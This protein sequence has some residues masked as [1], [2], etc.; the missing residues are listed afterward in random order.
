M[1][2]SEVTVI[3]GERREIVMSNYW[4]RSSQF[5]NPFAPISPDLLGN[6]KQRSDNAHFP[7]PTDRECPHCRRSRAGR[8][9]TVYGRQ[10]PVVV[11]NSSSSDKLRASVRQIP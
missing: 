11:L 1:T 7:L 10:P 4:R 9:P 5:Q 2:A 3:T 8:R 6:G